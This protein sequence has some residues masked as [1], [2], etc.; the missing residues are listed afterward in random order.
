VR[1][2]MMRRFGYFVAESSAYM[3]EYGPCFIKRDD[4]MR[5]FNIPI[6]EYVRCSS[7][8][9]A[10]FERTRAEVESGAPIQIRLSH[11]YAA[12]IIRAIEANTDWSFNGNV[13]NSMDRRS[14]ALIP[15]LPADAI[16]EVP[17][18]TNRAGLQPCHTGEWPGGVVGLDRSHITVHSL[19][20]EVALN[21]SRDALQQAVM[22]DPHTA[23]VLTLDEIWCMTDELV[24][25][26]GDALPSFTTRR[27]VGAPGRPS[28][29]GEA[30]PPRDLTPL[31][32][33]GA[34]P[35]NS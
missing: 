14:A 33:P 5:E 32:S 13:P 34:K 3:A 6:N 27:L 15:N 12:Y 8:N 29:Q 25:A 21:G 7:D 16:V 19:A 20:V 30:A 18:L 17:I 26:D 1:F 2:E 4:L 31:A 35:R 11:E 22:L 24:E 23:S 9:L 10:T 28:Q